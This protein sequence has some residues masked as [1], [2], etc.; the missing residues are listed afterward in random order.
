MVVV[1]TAAAMQL[2]YT[3]FMVCRSNISKV[4]YIVDF[5]L[6]PAWTGTLENLLKAYQ[7][8]LLK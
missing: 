7:T 8:S 1:I 2:S 6:S 3:Q 4:T 5:L